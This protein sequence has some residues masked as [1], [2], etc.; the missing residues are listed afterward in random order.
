M[1]TVYEAGPTILGREDEDAAQ[2]IQEWLVK[3]GVILR[4]GAKI[5]SIEQTGGKGTGEPKV[6]RVSYTNAAGEDVIDE[7]DELLVSAGR[8]PNI[9]VC[10]IVL[11][12][13]GLEMIRLSCIS[14]DKE[15]DAVHELFHVFMH[16]TSTS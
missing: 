15:S 3:D 11:R 6:I 8:T 13:F 14:S 5:K 16:S 1:V 10:T 7:L 9:E 12:T 4:L 2:I